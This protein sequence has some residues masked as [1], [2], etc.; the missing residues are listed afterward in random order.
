M[1]TS[2]I[3]SLAGRPAPAG[4][5]AVANQAP[6]LVPAK[7]LDMYRSAIAAAV[8]GNGDGRI[9]EAEFE[10]QLI[11]AGA[12]AEDAKAHWQTLGAG[13]D[14]TIS[15]DAYASSVADPFGNQRDALLK[16]I[17]DELRRGAG[18]A[19]P[20]GEV[21]NAAGQVADPHATLRFLAARFPGNMQY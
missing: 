1:S 14:G 21:L 4:Q 19:Q 16:S 3:D 11:Q 8:D 2:A 5:S 10:H 7:F 12:S 20:Q 6:G 13:A 9:S 15:D 18:A 17:V